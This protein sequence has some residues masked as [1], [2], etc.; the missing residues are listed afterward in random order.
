MNTQLALVIG[1]LILQYGPE[2]VQALIKIFNNNAPTQTDW[3]NAFALA[4]NPIV[5]VGDMPKQQILQ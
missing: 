4:K 1:Q 5:Q 2:F 3:D